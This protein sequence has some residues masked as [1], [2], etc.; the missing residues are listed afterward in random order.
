MSEGNGAPAQGATPSPPRLTTGG[1]VSGGRYELL[2]P[3]GGVAGQAFWRARDKRLGRD[4]ALTF[5][6]PLPGEQAPGSA[7]GVLDRTVA[8][9]GVYSDGLA[10]VLDVIR[11]RAGGIVVS[12][13]VPGRS[14]AAAAAEPDP[15]TAVGAVWGL[16]DAATRAQ[17]SGLVLGLD[18]PD[19]IRLTEDGRALLAFPGVGPSV[20]ARG[21]VRGLGAVLYGLLTGAWPV[22]LPEGSDQHDPRD[23]RLP[24]APVDD[25]EVPR[26]P[27][28]VGSGVPQDSAV[29]AMRSLDGSS[30]SSAATVRSMISERT[31]GPVR[32]PA[33]ARG[34]T[35]PATTAAAATAG[36]A[37]T[38]AALS[39]S[40]TGPSSTEPSTPAQEWGAGADPDGYGP[41]PYTP[42]D[43]ETQKRRWMI[44]AGTAAVAVIAVA[45]LAAWML[46]ALTSDDQETPLSQQL[47]AIE[48][49]AEQSRESEA[50]AAQTPED[51]G[52]EAPTETETSSAPTAPVEVSDATSWQPTSSAGTA[53]NP[54]GASNVIDGDSSTSWSTDTYRNQLG[55]GGSALKPGVGLLLTLDDEQE[56]GQAVVRSDDDG[57]RFE[58]R[59]ADSASPN[60]LE[61]TTLLGEGT[62]RDGSGTVTIDDPEQAEHVVVWITRLG[63]TGPQSFKADITEVELT[64]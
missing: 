40:S 5:V 11:G 21:D 55:D 25:D 35:R 46:G 15:G 38:G 30:V 20:D 45:L 28:E 18:S 60:S 34:A 51:D 44:M 26:D 12:E 53:E 27:T 1:L 17:E 33:A 23:D 31:G 41:E 61:D 58:V 13:W 9:T 4:V 62:I 2:E 36:A 19:R 59:S 54:S 29:L 3:H 6:D 43:E 64:G 10:R 48:R 7:T 47:D 52:A 50:S 14:L 16:S 32:G 49:A 42:P 22:A 63:A 37:G 8:L 57:V 39:S 24:S 56:V